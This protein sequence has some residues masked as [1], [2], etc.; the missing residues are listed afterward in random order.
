MTISTDGFR[1]PVTVQLDA[2]TYRAIHVAAQRASEV[3]EREVSMRELIETRLADAVTGVRR[4]A[5]SARREAPAPVEQ[6]RDG[7]LSTEQ[8]ERRGGRLSAEQRDL[9]LTMNK[10]GSTA[11]EIATAVGCHTAT[12]AYYR[13][14]IRTVQPEGESNV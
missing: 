6:P 10:A 3:A 4:P 5:P 8:R 13:N 7:Q 12:V 11:L 14:K 1:I 2:R 9:L